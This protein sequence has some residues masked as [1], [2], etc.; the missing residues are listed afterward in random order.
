[1]TKFSIF[2]IFSIFR[3]TTSTRRNSNG[4]LLTTVA[5]RFFFTVYR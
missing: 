2:E 3:T 4:R 5:V 1:M